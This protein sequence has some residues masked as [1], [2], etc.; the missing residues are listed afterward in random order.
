VKRRSPK[1]AAKTLAEMSDT[2]FRKIVSNR[3]KFDPLPED[4]PR[5]PVKQYTG[6]DDLIAEFKKRGKVRDGDLIRELAL[7]MGES[8]FLELGRE[9]RIRR[10][11]IHLVATRLFGVVKWGREMAKAQKGKKRA[12]ARHRDWQAKANAIWTKNPSLSK[13]AVAIPMTRNAGSN[14]RADTVRR[15]IVKPK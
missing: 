4:R 14:I 1:R 11:I 9:V 10:E 7:A 8:S 2:E 13:K 5:V 6:T 3:Y 15:V 12:A